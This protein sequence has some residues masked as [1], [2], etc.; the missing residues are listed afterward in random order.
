MPRVKL[1][2]SSCSNFQS[3]SS[4]FCRRASIWL[5]RMS[6]DAVA[7]ALH[8]RAGGEQAERHLAA[9]VEADERALGGE[10]LVAVHQAEVLAGIEA[11]GFDDGGDH[12][13]DL[14]RLRKG[15]VEGP[16]RG[17]NM[18]RDFIGLRHFSIS[19][20]RVCQR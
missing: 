5:S 13:R 6:S 9:E 7:M 15:A 3:C 16:R 4:A 14:R 18:E 12:R 8:A 17:R 10:L 19:F 2:G 1:A 20:R 11:L